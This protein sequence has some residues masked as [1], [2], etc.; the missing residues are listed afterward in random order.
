MSNNI[1]TA[2]LGN[3]GSY[4]V[5]GAP[6]ASGSIVCHNLT[7]GPIVI[8]FPYVTKWVHIQNNSTVAAEDLRVGFS[9]LGITNSSNYFVLPNRQ[10]TTTG[11]RSAA[12]RF[13]LNMKLTEIWISGS[14]N[15][16]IV[17]GLTNIPIE[18]ITNISPSGS[19]WSG[20]SGVG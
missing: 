5:S 18:R 17:A 12:S 10:A 14:S 16:D 20:S 3:V 4:Q 13:T 19:N 15:V 6:Y 9:S 7:Q 1:Y 2:G 11:D 8:Q